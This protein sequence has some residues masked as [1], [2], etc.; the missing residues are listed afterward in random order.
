MIRNIS[1]KNIRQIIDIIKY[2]II[3]DKT[4]KDLENNVYYFAVQKNTCKDEIKAAIESTFNVKIKKINTILYPPK[5]KRV[6]KFKGRITQYK[7]AIVKLHSN[8]KIN[9]FEEN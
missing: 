7:K 9:L 1:D 3:T 8:Y 4:T 5:T 2:P 6:G